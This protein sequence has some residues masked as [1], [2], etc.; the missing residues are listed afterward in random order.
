[1]AALS[2]SRVGLTIVA[3]VAAVAAVFVLFRAIDER[4]APPIVIEDADRLQ[5]IVIELRGA[6]A[7]P[8]VYELGPEARL[9]D[10]IRAGGGLTADADLS[11][12]NLAR[13]L[14]D[15][16][17]VVVAA[18]LEGA[19]TPAA[20]SST[21]T[22]M[23]G[24]TTDGALININTGTAAALELLPGIGEVTAQRIIEYREQNGPYR[25]VDDLVHVQGI[26]TRTIDQLRDLV[27]TA[28]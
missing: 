16:E 21:S 9:Q 20:P 22:S 24:E 25:S 5:P 17:V 26:S 4:A 6:V 23:E 27:T 12:V 8:G 19:G 10:A 7:A 1:M 13:R 14:R 2:L 18:L 11:T 15:G 28:P 3:I